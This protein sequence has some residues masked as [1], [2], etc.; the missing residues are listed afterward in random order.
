MEVKPTV[1]PCTTVER[2][3][4]AVVSSPGHVSMYPL[5]H[6]GPWYIVKP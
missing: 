4:L 2:A 6:T 1:V 5:D 3:L